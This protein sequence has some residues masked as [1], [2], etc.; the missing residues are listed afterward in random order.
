MGFIERKHFDAA[1]WLVWQTRMLREFLCIAVT[2]VP[3]YPILQDYQI[4]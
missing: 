3:Y 4:C 1:A 2:S